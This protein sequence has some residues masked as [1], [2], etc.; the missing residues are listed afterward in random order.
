MAPSSSNG[1]HHAEIWKRSVGKLIPSQLEFSQVL[2]PT[3]KP[4]YEFSKLKKCRHWHWTWSE[5]ALLVSH[6]DHGHIH[7][8]KIDIKQANIRYRLIKMQQRTIWGRYSYH[9]RPNQ[10]QTISNVARPD[11]YT[12]L[13]P[14]ARMQAVCGIGSVISSSL[15]PCFILCAHSSPAQ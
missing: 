3:M 4:Y 10:R 12:C 11:V 6:F 8:C 2:S 7:K 13:K 9:K 1:M 15:Q 14:E 5:N